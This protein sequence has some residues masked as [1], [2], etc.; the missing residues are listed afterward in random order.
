M[1]IRAVIAQL[2]YFRYKGFELEFGKSVDEVREQI[3]S[4]LPKNSAPLIEPSMIRLAEISPR[5]A[6]LEA[7]RTLELAAQEA[8]RH[9]GDEPLRDGRVRFDALHYLHQKKVI[10]PQIINLLYKLR[11]L[12][13]RAAHAPDFAL[14]TESAIGYGVSAAVLAEYLR[15]IA[16]SPPQS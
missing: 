16:D 2:Q 3:V 15:Q 5:L 9:I 11:G 14:T 4:E 6:V 13:N 10:N 7:W 8:A 1:P 12:R